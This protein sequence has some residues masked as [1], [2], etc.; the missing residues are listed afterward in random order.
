MFRREKKGFFPFIHFGL[1]DPEGLGTGTGRI[2][3]GSAPL[4]PGRKCSKSISSFYSGR[5]SSLRT[6]LSR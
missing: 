6:R 4:S 3:S 2:K 5:S 1:F